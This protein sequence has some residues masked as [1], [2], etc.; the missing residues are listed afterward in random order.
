MHSPDASPP[1]KLLITEGLGYCCVWAFFCCYSRTQ[2]I[3]DRLGCQRRVVQ[4]WRR[5]FREGELGCAGC[6]KCMREALVKLGKVKGDDS[7]VG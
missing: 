6:D 3:A 5:R 1:I 4:E 7:C 2:V